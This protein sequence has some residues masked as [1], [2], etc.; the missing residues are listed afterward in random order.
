ML[1]GIVSHRCPLSST[2][3]DIRIYVGPDDTEG[4]QMHLRLGDL[5]LFTTITHWHAGA[6]HLSPCD[7]LPK[8]VN[9]AMHW[10]SDVTVTDFATHYKLKM[11]KE[12]Q[13][14]TDRIGVKANYFI[15][16]YNKKIQS[17]QYYSVFTA[18]KTHSSSIASEPNNSNT[19][20][21]SQRCGWLYCW[22]K[23]TDTSPVC[24]GYLVGPERWYYLQIASGVTFPLPCGSEVIMKFVI[25]VFRLF[26]LGQTHK[27]DKTLFSRT[28]QNS[29]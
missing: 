12:L 28:G 25:F 13:K 4:K 19:A 16:I 24:R 11:N 22:H 9:L 5:L 2:G 20:H 14:N 23:R 1:N 10:Y 27:N 29:N 15:N 6:G 26:R 18:S 7:M 8:G 17:R 3:R 21:N